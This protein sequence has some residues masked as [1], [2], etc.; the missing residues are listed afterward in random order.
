MSPR[1]K[2][3]ADSRNV[4]E[5]DEQSNDF[6]RTEHSTWHLGWRAAPR[7]VG[8]TRPREWMIAILWRELFI[9]LRRESGPAARFR[10]NSDA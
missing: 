2:D 4:G 8:R 9:C 6:E 3:Q 7:V 10:H 5:Q 1:F